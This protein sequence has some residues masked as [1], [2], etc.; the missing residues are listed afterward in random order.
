MALKYDE[1]AAGPAIATEV[2]ASAHHEHGK[3]VW[4]GAGAAKPIAESSPLPA[5][6]YH[7]GVAMFDT[8][9]VL[10]A[11]GAAVLVTTA[12]DQWVDAL[13]LS[14]Q[15]EVA[16]AFVLTDGN[17]LSYGGRDLEPK[18]LRAVPFFGCRFEG[19]V[20]LGADN[21]D[22]IRVQVKGTR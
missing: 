13:L 12:A 4:G 14:N 11:A 1:P 2:I 21:A 6:D 22:A 5:R 16:Q 9:L 18:E 17:G 15:T 19:G 8:G 3:P 10:V 20:M 7:G